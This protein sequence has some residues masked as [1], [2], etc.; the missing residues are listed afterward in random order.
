MAR[1]THTISDDNLG[2][3][4]LRQPKDPAD[5]PELHR[6]EPGVCGGEGDWNQIGDDHEDYDAGMAAFIEA[7]LEGRGE[8]GTL[9]DSEESALI[10]EEQDA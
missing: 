1:K 8:P 3:L 6:Y 5:S 4:Q 2:Q 9:D 7:L 10:G